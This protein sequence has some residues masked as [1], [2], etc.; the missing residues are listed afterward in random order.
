M[1]RMFPNYEVY[2]SRDSITPEGTLY[3]ALISTEACSMLS[4]E[5]S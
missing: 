1:E 5:A 4:Y 3:R 2:D